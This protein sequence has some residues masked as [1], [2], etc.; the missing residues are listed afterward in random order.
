MEKH[1][2]FAQNYYT[3]ILNSNFV[4]KITKSLNKCI[5]CKYMS[6]IYVISLILINLDLNKMSVF[7][8]VYIW[9]DSLDCYEFVLISKATW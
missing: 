9:N 3:Y 7:V 6:E 2:Y 8:Q 1:V 4:Y 5:M